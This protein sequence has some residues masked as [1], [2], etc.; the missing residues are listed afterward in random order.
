VRLGYYLTGDNAR[1][2]ADG[3]YYI[4]GRADDVIIVSGHNIGTAEVESALVRPCSLST[5]D[6]LAPARDC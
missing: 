1:R 3:Y 6:C 5:P 2:D 4:T